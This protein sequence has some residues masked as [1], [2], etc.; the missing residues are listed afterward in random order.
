M[1][2]VPVKLWQTLFIHFKVFLEGQKKQVE[3]W[4]HSSFLFNNERDPYLLHYPSL[5]YRADRQ[6]GR[7]LEDFPDAFISGGIG[8]RLVLPDSVPSY[9]LPT[10]FL[11]EEEMDITIGGKWRVSNI[12]FSGNKLTIEYINI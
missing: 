2:I 7:G 12:S 3:V 4:A 1:E 11:T 10:N 8:P 6:F 9:V 5:K